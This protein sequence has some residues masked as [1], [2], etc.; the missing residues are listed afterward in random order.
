M[1]G[2]KSFRLVSSYSETNKQE[3]RIAVHA[4]QG[5]EGG[6]QQIMKGLSFIITRRK[7]RAR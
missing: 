4:T 5:L 6:E 3:W 1:P 2:W 7:G